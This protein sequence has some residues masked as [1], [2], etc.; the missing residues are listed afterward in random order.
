VYLAAFIVLL[1]VSAPGW[2]VIASAVS[3]VL[4]ALDATWLTLR[5]RRLD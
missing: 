1:L 3:V 4:L 5:I 2:I